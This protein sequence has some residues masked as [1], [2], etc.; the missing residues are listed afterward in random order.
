MN[1]FMSQTQVKEELKIGKVYAK[2]KENDFSIIMRLIIAASLFFSIA[3][4]I[5]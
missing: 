3:V 2:E 5:F 4:T 1:T